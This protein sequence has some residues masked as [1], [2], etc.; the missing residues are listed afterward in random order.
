MSKTNFLGYVKEPSQQQKNLENLFS[1]AEFYA[2][3]NLWAQYETTQKQIENF[4]LKN[5]TA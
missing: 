1:W 3:A 2:K 4:N 5:Q